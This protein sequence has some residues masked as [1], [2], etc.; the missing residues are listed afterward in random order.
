MILTGIPESRAQEPEDKV[1][2][3]VCALKALI[4]DLGVQEEI[5][6][7]SIFR[8][9]HNRVNRDDRWRPA[10]DRPRL[11]KAVLVNDDMKWKIL[12]EGGKPKQMDNPNRR[13]IRIMPDHTFKE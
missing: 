8:I 12:K 9:N 6:V 11:L 3:D 1:E 10:M 4:K 5:E 2:D 13:N 7:K